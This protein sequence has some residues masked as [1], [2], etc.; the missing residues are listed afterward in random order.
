[1]KTE[2]ANH[3]PDFRFANLKA[4]RKVRKFLLSAGLCDY[5]VLI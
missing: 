1:M 3:P 5:G 2:T 4:V